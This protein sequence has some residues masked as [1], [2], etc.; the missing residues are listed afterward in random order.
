MAILRGIPLRP[1]SPPPT[2][3]SPLQRT[4]N[5]RRAANKL[6]KKS[7]RYADNVI[8]DH[9][10]RVSQRSAQGRCGQ[11]WCARTL[12]GVSSTRALKYAL[13]W[14][15]AFLFAAIF[16]ELSFRG[17]L[18]ATLGSGIGFWPA[19]LVLSLGFAVVHLGNPGEKWPGILM[20]FW[21]GMLAA[22]TLRLTGDLWFIIGLHT[23]WDW[24]H[25]FLFSVPIAGMRG[26]PQLLNASLQGPQWL[27]GGRIGPDGSMFVFVVLTL[28]AG[29]I[30]W[31]FSSGSRNDSAR[32]VMK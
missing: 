14:A 5:L 2:K 19:A 21:F 18:Q 7:F 13:L 17:Y 30:Y 25:M 4:E 12:D 20:L 32:S 8:H 9:L 1:D 6:Q 11:N 28:L 27:T 22:L 29:I 16:E 3:R 26:E 31:A 23:S 15:V 24:A 10:I